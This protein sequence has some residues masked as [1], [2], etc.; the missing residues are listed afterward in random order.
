MKQV[1]NTSIKLWIPEFTLDGPDYDKIWC[2][3][4]WMI[5]QN[6]GFDEPYSFYMIDYKMLTPFTMGIKDR[7]LAHTFTRKYGKWMKMGVTADQKIGIAQFSN[8]QWTFVEWECEDPRMQRLWVHLY[9]AVW[10]GADLR[11]DLF[12]MDK[13]K[14]GR[15]VF[16]L[17]TDT[18]WWEHAWNTTRP[19]DYIPHYLKPPLSSGR[20]DQFPG[21]IKIEHNGSF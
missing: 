12:E 2:T 13:L 9:S 21:K 5:G 3:F 6:Y 4:W 16:H 15:G 17:H 18:G 14:R 8:I 10:W 1:T 11:K 7:D 19:A 20:H